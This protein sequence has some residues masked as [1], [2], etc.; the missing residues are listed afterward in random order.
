MHKDRLDKTKQFR[1]FLNGGPKSRN[2]VSLEPSSYASILA[3][4]PGGNPDIEDEMTFHQTF[5][6]DA[7]IH[8]LPNYTNII[9]ELNWKRKRL[10]QQQ[11]GTIV[12]EERIELPGGTKQRVI[13]E[14]PGTTPWIIEPAVNSMEDFDLIDYYAEC[15]LK[16]TSLIA[17]SASEYPKMAGDAAMIPG[18]IIFSAFETYW[19]IDYPDMPLFFMDWPERFIKSIKKVHAAN[20]ALM[21]ALVNIG[22]EIV[23]TGSAGL[24]LLSPNIFTEAIV[25]FQREFNDHARS[26]GC[27]SSYHICGHSRQLI[28]DK[29]IDQIKPTIF[30]TCSTTPCGD[31]KS[32][33]DAVNEIDEEIITKGNLPLELLRNGSP[34]HIA[35]LVH[36][37]YNE[38]KQRRH[39]IGQGD[40]TIL[41]G[42]PP[43][44]IRA[45]LEAVESLNN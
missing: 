8:F 45:F 33:S 38:T 23:F 15:I 35:E 32:L 16:N 30:E 28:E 14:P 13:K 7:T 22:V 37:I 3:G 29:I 18:A 19:L 9:P 43:E 34:D 36:Q 31:N 5:P 11:N 42:T 44:N 2:F 20:M 17:E 39:I 27:H 40:A 26:L 1:S 4:K 25:P 12:W 10:E 41:D 21:E 6:N 24:E